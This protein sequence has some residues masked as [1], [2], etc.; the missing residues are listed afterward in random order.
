MVDLP[1]PDSPTSAKVVPVRDG[2]RN[3]VDG[4]QVTPWLPVEDA[5]QERAGDVEDV[6]DRDGL[7]R[8]AVNHGRCS[9]Q[10]AWVGPACEQ[11]G[12]IGPA[13]G[14][15]TGAA[16]MEAA[17][18]GDGVQARH[19]AVDLAQAGDAMLQGRNAGH[20][21][22]GVGVRGLPDNRGDR[23][24]FGDTASIHDGDTVG[25]FGDDAHVVGDQ[26]NGGAMVAGQALSAG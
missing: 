8:C 16:G 9:Q 12:L 11:F 14:E 25:G 2:E 22:I 26:H 18:G 1:Q 5:L 13:T 6:G 20:Q 7:Q 23:A 3:V 19:R 21:A 15:D 4:S 24:D 10:A 17:A